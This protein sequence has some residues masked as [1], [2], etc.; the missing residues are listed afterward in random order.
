MLIGVQKR[1][2]FIANSKTASTSIEAALIGHAEIARGGGAHRKHLRMAQILREY[3]FLFGQK[4]YAPETFFKFGVMRD[5]ID[6]IFSWYRFR[7]GNKVSNPLPE[8]TTFEEFWARKDW[9]I[10]NAKGQKRLQCDFFTDSKGEL[11][12]DYIIPHH[13]LAEHFAGIATALGI[14]SGLPRTN[15]SRIPKSADRGIDARLEEELRDFYAE[16]YALFE[17]LDEINARGKDVLQE[18]RARAA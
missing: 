2:V 7:R 17:R 14:E 1:F 5:P 6:W 4:A 13:D 16:D 18:T 9:N 10:L 3:D 11:L 15:V 12:A 8:E